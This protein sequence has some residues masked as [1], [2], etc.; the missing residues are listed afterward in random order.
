MAMFSLALAGWNG[1]RYASLFKRWLLMCLVAC[2]FCAYAAIGAGQ[3]VWLT[4]W[5]LTMGTTF[6]LFAIVFSVHAFRA[7]RAWT[8]RAVAAVIWL[9]CLI[10]IRD[11]YVF[12]ID[13]QYPQITWLRFSSVLFGVILLWV[14]L[15][16]FKHATWL[17][18][19]LMN[20]MQQRIADRESELQTSYQ[21]MEQLARE[22]ERAS[23]RGRILRDMHDGVGAHISSAIRQVESGRASDE[24]VLATLR[25]SLDQ[26]KLSIDAMNLPPG[27]VTSLL[28]NLRYRLGGRL[29]ACGVHLIWNVDMVP[30]VERL[31][32]SAMR[33][34]QFIF[35]EALSNILQHAKC[36][37][38]EVQALS[39]G[40]SIEIR[41]ADNGV[42][43]DPEKASTR[44]LKLM[45]DRALGIGAALHWSSVPGATVLRVLLP[46]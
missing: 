15:Q 37:V 22:Q 44:G 29:Q 7:G 6:L 18:R 2:P 35:F 17:S 20:T 31:D 45:K 28:A 25:D 32:A 8:Q 39:V 34:L 9:N 38:I 13:P 5:Y 40:A 36:S 23:E 26:L 12:R 10:G 43:F 19:D 46:L 14:V 41:I 42:G 16:R 27:D 4:M 24:E 21:R 30:L 33:Q 3:A 1:S 11:V